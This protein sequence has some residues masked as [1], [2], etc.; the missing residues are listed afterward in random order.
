[1][2]PSPQLHLAYVIIVFIIIIIIIG[3]WV[4]RPGYSGTFWYP[5][6]MAAFLALWRPLSEVS[7]SGLQDTLPWHLPVLLPDCPICEESVAP[8]RLQ[9]PPPLSPSSILAGVRETQVETRWN[10]FHKPTVPGPDY[11]TDPPGSF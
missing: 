10:G 2:L 6:S 8:A 1:M 5:T 3:C 4:V 11:R 9:A 7:F